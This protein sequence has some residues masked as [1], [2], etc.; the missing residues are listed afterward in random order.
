MT[1]AHKMARSPIESIGSNVLRAERM[2]H[3][4]SANNWAS[5]VDVQVVN[6]SQLLVQ[7]LGSV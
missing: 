3:L 6:S 7:G 5:C 1:I 2:L 4:T